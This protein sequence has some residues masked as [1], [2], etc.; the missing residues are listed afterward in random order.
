MHDKDILRVLWVHQIDSTLTLIVSNKK[1][2]SSSLQTCERH[3]DSVCKIHISACYI[4]L[5]FHETGG[6]GLG[7][8]IIYKSIV[9]VS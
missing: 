1:I 5:L 2:S 4:C 9:V 6:Q 7:C 8:T 3:G